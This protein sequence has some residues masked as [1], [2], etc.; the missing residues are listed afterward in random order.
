M[1]TVVFVPVKLPQ[2]MIK[3][4]FGGNQAIDGFFLEGKEASTYASTYSQISVALN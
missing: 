4:K 2:V 3:L 1:I